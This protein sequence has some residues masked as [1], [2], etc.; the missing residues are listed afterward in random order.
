MVFCF[1]ACILIL[2]LSLI[3]LYVELTKG[4]VRSSTCL[5]GKTVLITGGNSGLGYQT[6]LAL[7]GR[8]AKVIIA[9]C[10]DSTESRRKIIEKTGNPNVISKKFDLLSLESIRSFAK[11]IN[12]EESRLDI[13]I[14]NAGTAQ[15][16]GFSKDGLA[17]H[18][19][20]N[21]FGGFLLTHLLIDLL[22]KSA[23]SRI[24]FIS[25]ALAFFNN[26]TIKNLNET[27]S[28]DYFSYGNTKLCN[29]IISNGFAQKLLG[30]GVTSN[31]VHPGAVKTP[32]FDVFLT[33]FNFFFG[34]IWTLIM[35][36]VGK[37][38][39]EGA[40]C[41]IHCALSKRL[42]NVTGKYFIDCRE[43]FQPFGIG[44]KAFCNE[45]WNKCE[46]LV[47]LKPEEKL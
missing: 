23:P 11:E 36:F 45:I 15:T 43:F 28:N 5:I 38:A 1:F 33:Q 26:L 4:K 44:N 17:G 24:I 42:E 6:A 10:N 7:A 37:D 30:S 14:N 3:K 31:A 32:I 16:L 12:A 46:E 22:K 39:F 18:M 2:I 8:G 20:V 41:Q 21:N 27:I 25:S 9:D 19:Q 13:L 29:I 47:K 40:Q 35:R 34:W